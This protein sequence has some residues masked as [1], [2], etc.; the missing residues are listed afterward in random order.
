MQCGLG[1]AQSWPAVGLQALEGQ[2]G[3]AILTAPAEFRFELQGRSVFS[4][5]HSGVD[6]PKL[7]DYDLCFPMTSIPLNCLRRKFPA[8]R[9]DRSFRPLGVAPFLMPEA[10]KVWKMHAGMLLKTFPIGEIYAFQPDESLWF[11]PFAEWTPDDWNHK[12]HRSM[13]WDIKKG[14][15]LR[16]S[17]VHNRDKIRKIGKPFTKFD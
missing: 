16:A 2:I 3:D 9:E 4:P 5:T 14:I 15:V 8:W 17:G 1:V 11:K 10:A 7:V 12:A 6:C 13:L